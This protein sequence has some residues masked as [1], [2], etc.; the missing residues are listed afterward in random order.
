MATEPSQS[1][2][3]RVSDFAQPLV[4]HLKRDAEVKSILPRRRLSFL[5]GGERYCYLILKGCVM[6][7]RESDDLAVASATAPTLVGIVNLHKL[8]LK[9]YIKTLV[10]CEIAILKMATVHNVIDTHQLWEP[11]AKHMM[12]MA[13]KLF[14]SSEQLS[15]PTAYEIVRAQLNELISEAPVLRENTTAERYIRDKTHLSRSGIMRILAGLKEGG[16]IEMQRGLLTGIVKLPEK[17]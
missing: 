10:P 17:F 3:L 15:A 6:A 4:E 7:H 8:E 14:Q 9:G 5:V 13:G 11:L 12:V 16:Y 2:I 1:L